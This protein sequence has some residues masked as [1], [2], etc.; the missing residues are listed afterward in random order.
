[1][2]NFALSHFEAPFGGSFISGASFSPD[3]RLLALSGFSGVMLIDT[4]SHKLVRRLR[5][6]LENEL[7]KPEVS[8]ERQLVR[9]FDAYGRIY[10]WD[11]RSGR[12]IGQG[13]AN[14]ALN[15]N[16]PAQMPILSQSG[17]RFL[18]QTQSDFSSGSS[19]SLERLQ[20]AIGVEKLCLAGEGNDLPDLT[21]RRSA[22]L[23]V[24]TR[25]P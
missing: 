15:A 18:L 21:I 9:A 11:L 4:Q 8:A 1:M 23:M 5:A 24:W 12:L 10:E 17:G 2:Q 22:K 25:T 6:P 3:L 19:V 13:R 14:Y 7:G 16:G 20:P